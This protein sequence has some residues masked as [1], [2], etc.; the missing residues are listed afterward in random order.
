MQA[1][2]KSIE[3][4]ALAG[5]SARAPS[6][7]LGAIKTASAK[8]GVDF[9]Y[10]MEKASAESSFNPNAK[11][12]TS[13][14]TGLFQF[15][16]STWMGMVKKHGEKYGINPDQSRQSLLNLRKDPA[17]ASFM[18]AEFA[19]GNKAH[20][21]KT[22]GGNIGNTELYFAHFMGAG[23]A[24]AFLSQLKKNPLGIGA[25]LFPKEANANRNVFYDSKTGSARTL[26]EIYNFFDKKFADTENAAPIS[27]AHKPQ[28]S[29]ANTIPAAYKKGYKHI[30]PS[31]KKP[32]EIIEAQRHMN[33]LY[34][35]QSQ[36][37]AFFSKPTGFYSAM[38]QS[39]NAY[40]RLDNPSSILLNLLK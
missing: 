25:D 40:D 39:N 29:G 30:P 28:K 4:N 31:L 19:K 24:S 36:L 13:S 27:L 5:L 3:N 14:A 32:I 17:L 38:A 20:L 33:N 10:L 8:T 1:A 23:G 12:K 26:Q 11:A 2:L 37:D 6:N 15:I 22:V 9:A 35:I 21:E 34:H 16:E 7:V 18:A